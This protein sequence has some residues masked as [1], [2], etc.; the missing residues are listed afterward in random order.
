MKPLLVYLSD[1]DHAEL[2]KESFEKGVSM[3]SLLKGAY[4]QYKFE[5]P[6]PKISKTIKKDNPIVE[7]E[8][9]HAIAPLDKPPYRENIT[10]C[11]H[12]MMVGLCK[13][14]CK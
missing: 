3:G 1:E 4:F 11:K 12:G 10:L 7:T 2:R 8:V 5:K 6:V 9:I 13:H 14:G